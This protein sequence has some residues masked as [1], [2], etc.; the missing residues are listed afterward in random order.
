VI[1]FAASDT[2]RWTLP[3]EDP[4][5]RALPRT[6]HDR[7]W[8][9]MVLWLAHQDEV[10]GNVYVRP[11]FRRL[12]VN[13]RQTIKMG[14]RD[15]RGDEIPEAEIHYQILRP[16]ETA[17]KTKAK[18]AE[19]DP[20]GGARASFEAKVPDE[21]T[22]VAWGEGKDAN[23]EDVKGDARARYV[24]YPEVSN[25]MLRPAANPEFLLALENTA[26][27][28]AQDVARRADQLP[29]FL[30][31]MKAKPPTL[32]TPKPKPY[33][34]WRRDKQQWFLPAVLVLFV[35]VLGL[36]WGLRRAW[37]MV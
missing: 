2:W 31:G 21:Y 16:G 9:Q 11:E 12:V 5:N 28:T 6:L 19:R 32:S 29:K 18:R 25:E 1:A 27:G 13:G 3:G 30:E 35:A 15:K 8:K 26:N 33:P 22:V 20:R 37:G 17:D 23:G 34:D 14:V 24:V 7:F 4:N 36:E 10:E